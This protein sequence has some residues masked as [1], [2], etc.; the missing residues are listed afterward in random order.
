MKHV[1]ALG[2]QEASTAPPHLMKPLPGVSGMGSRSLAAI[3]R[4]VASMLPQLPLPSS[5]AGAAGGSWGWALQ[6]EQG[7]AAQQAYT[8]A[9]AAAAAAGAAAPYPSALASAAAIN[10][11]A[12]GGACPPAAAAGAASRSYLVPNMSGFVEPTGASYIGH[13]GVATSTPALAAAHLGYSYM[14]LGAAVSCCD[15]LP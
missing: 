3:N 13:G 5:V 12:C 4:G 14:D 6:G 8:N 15:A 7:P 2:L 9:L 11:A 1:M 10:R